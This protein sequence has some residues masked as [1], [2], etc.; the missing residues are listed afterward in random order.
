MTNR[1]LVGLVVGSSVISDVLGWTEGAAFV[2]DVDGV[3]VVDIASSV[4]DDA[5]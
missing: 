3:R 2:G 1:F 4:V 5:D